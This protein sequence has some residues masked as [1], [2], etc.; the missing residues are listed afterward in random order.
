MTACVNDICHVMEAI[1]PARLAES[2][3]NVGLQ[4]GHRGWPVETVMVALDP[5]TAVVAAACRVGAGLLVTHHPLIFKPLER[6]DLETPLGAILD[7]ALKHRLAIFAAH[8]N[9]D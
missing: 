3:D 8:T 6:L 7:M 2:W 5:L 1:A 9:L 4:V